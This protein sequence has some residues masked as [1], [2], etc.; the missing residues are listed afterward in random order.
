MDMD[1]ATIRRTAIIALF[2]DD[3]L[4]DMLALKGGNALSLV[5]G[6][7]SRTSVDLDFPGLP[8]LSARQRTD[9]PRAQGS[10]RFGWLHRLWRTA[11]AEAA[12]RK[13]G[14]Q[15]VVERLRAEFKLMARDRYGHRQRLDGLLRRH[16]RTTRLAWL[17]QSPD[18][19]NSGYMLEHI[20]RL[21]TWHELDLPVGI[22]HHVH[23]NR[24]LKLAREGGQVPPRT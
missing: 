22:E 1:F 9:L 16:S 18:K 20:A 10:L 8:R 2:A 4:A 5:H 12:R 15:T 13:R 24:L 6:I 3:E 19:P 14:H 11:H 7:T 17:H 21:K 23:Q